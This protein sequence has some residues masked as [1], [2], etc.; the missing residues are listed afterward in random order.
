LL[1]LGRGG[2]PAG[3]AGFEFAKVSLNGESGCT[4]L[5]VSSR[6]GLD[7]ARSSSA[8]VARKEI[9]SFLLSRAA[10]EPS[11]IGTS[12]ATMG[13]RIATASERTGESFEESIS[14][15]EVVTCSVRA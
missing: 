5:A 9:G 11:N 6:L 12:R 2:L 14:M 13:E 10:A 1:R 8:S 7:F 4:K 15:E 3:L